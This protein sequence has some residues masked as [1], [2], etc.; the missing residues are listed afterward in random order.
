MGFPFIYF[1]IARALAKRR[2][3]LCPECGSAVMVE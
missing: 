1:A 3:F 2:P